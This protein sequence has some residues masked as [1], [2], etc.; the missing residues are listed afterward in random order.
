LVFANW[1]KPIEEEG[2]WYFV[3][4]NKWKITLFFFLLMCY[5]LYKW[6]KASAVEIFFM[7]FVPLLFWFMFGSYEVAMTAGILVL[8]VVLL[9]EKD[10]ELGSWLE[11]TW[12]LARMIIPLLFYGVFA[13]GFFLGR[14]GYEGIIPSDW[15][16]FAV[17][18]NSIFSNF[19]ASIVG[20]FMYFATLTEVPILQ[21]LMGSGMGK[22]PALALLLSGPALSLQS[23]LIL[24]KIMGSRKT[25]VYV[26]LVVIMSSVVGW[27]YGMFF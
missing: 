23:M 18:G 8:S 13:A 26:S 27:F 17:G 16:K 25:V 7:I 4:L 9:K 11:Q 2:L 19:F 6:L 21:G 3:F 24:N 14:P 15:V 12:S 10:N 22:G 20:A 5:S 1:G